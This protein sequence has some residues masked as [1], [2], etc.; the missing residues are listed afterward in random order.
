MKRKKRSYILVSYFLL[1][2]SLGH[3]QQISYFTQVNQNNYIKNPAFAG[4]IGKYDIRGNYRMQW[5]GFKDAPSTQYLSYH[6]RIF[7]GK[8]GYGGYMMRDVTGPTKRAVYSLSYAYHII[9]SDVEA[10][11]G[12]AGSLQQYSLMGDKVTIHNSH[13]NSI[14]QNVNDKDLTGNASYGILLFNDRFHFGLSVFNQLQ[15][16]SKFYDNDST[17]N[18]FVRY[19]PHYHLSFGYN[20]SANSEFVFENNLSA[21]YTPNAPAV[22]GYNLRVVIKEKIMTGIAIRVKDAIALQAGINLTEEIQFMYSYDFITSKL[23]SSNSGSHEITFIYSVDSYGGKN[24]KNKKG[25]SSKRFAK[26]KYKKL[27]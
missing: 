23:R 17:K 18:S 10:S 26:Q 13:D 15:Q 9:F 2:G 22:V 6:S 19:E 16:K 8:M 24:S 27:F 5:V 11:F 3:A 20:Y 12:V 7:K 14:S 25:N 1:L 21:I 4:T